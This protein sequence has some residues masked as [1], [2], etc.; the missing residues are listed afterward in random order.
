[1]RKI[2]APV[3]LRKRIMYFSYNTMHADYTSSFCMYI[4]LRRSY[5]LPSVA[6]GV[7][8]YVVKC[9]SSISTKQP[10]KDRGVSLGTSPKL[11][12][13]HSSRSTFRTLPGSNSGHE[14]V[15]KITDRL[16][17]P[18]CAIP[19]KS[20]MSETVTDAFPQYRKYSYVILSHLLSNSNP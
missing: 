1:M 4:T 3:E 11:I 8:V 13:F 14:H 17:K 6:G 7:H 10:Y 16:I 15:L 20:T 2:L 5:F 19:L 9:K 18:S 12:P